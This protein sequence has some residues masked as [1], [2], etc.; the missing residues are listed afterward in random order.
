MVSTAIIRAIAAIQ[1]SVTRMS[2]RLS[3]MSPADPAGRASRKYGT[4]AAV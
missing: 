2:L 3:R 1:N 4:A